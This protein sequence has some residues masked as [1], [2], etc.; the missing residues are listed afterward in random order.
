MKVLGNATFENYVGMEQGFS[1]MGYQL[2]AHV[3]TLGYAVKLGGLFYFILA[4]KTVA[5]RYRISCVLSVFFSL[6]VFVFVG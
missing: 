4:M 6:L 2:V 5:R 1:E 3:L